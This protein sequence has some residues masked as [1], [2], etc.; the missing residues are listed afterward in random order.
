M[1][2]ISSSPFP[3]ATYRRHAREFSIEKFQN[4]VTEGEFEAVNLKSA[5]LITSLLSSLVHLS[6]ACLFLLAQLVRMRDKAEREQHTKNT[7][8]RKRSAH[9][10]HK[11]NARYRVITNVHLQLRFSVLRLASLRTS[12]MRTWHTD[13]RTQT[14][15]PWR[16][17]AL[18]H[19]S[20]TA[21]CNTSG[22][23]TAIS[24]RLNPKLSSTQ[25]NKK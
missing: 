14:S 24:T 1:I 8:R 2:A 23:G 22:S 6:Q 19:Y 21:I 7:K 5:K 25:E 4:R 16:F 12:E 10:V 15:M 20:T 17:D 3:R 18:M 13:E 9:K 11:A